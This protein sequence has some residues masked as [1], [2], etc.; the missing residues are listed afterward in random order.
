MTIANGLA[1]RLDAAGVA[2]W[3]ALAATMK[4][5]GPVCA[6]QEMLVVAPAAMLAAVAW[7]DRQPI[8]RRKALCDD[9]IGPVEEPRAH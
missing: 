1:A 5:V 7:L 6:W 4:R 2:A 3:A 9:L 8:E